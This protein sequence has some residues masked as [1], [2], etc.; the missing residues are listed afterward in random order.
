MYKQTISPSELA[1]L[2]AAYRAFEKL[3]APSGVSP[4]LYLLEPAEKER[5]LRFFTER[6]AQPGEIIVQEDTPGDAIH[7]IS[8]GQTAVI[9]GGFPNPTILGFRGAGEIIGEMA[10]LENSARFASVIALTPLRLLS[11]SSEKFDQ[12]IGENPDISRKIMRVLSS[13][14]RQ[15]GEEK[16]SEQFLSHQVDELREQAV[17]DVLTG[18]FNRR[19]LEETLQREF[20]RARRENLAVSILIMDVDHF[21]HIND[22]YGHQAGDYVLQEFGRLLQ[23]CVRLEDIVC[24]FGGDEFVVVM[25]GASAE[26]A[27]ERGERIRASFDALFLTFEGHAIGATLSMGAATLPAH[28]AGADEV[29]AMADQALYQAKQAG[30]NRVMVAA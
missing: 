15:A 7:L 24:R 26:V 29:L 2:L 30:R 25:P 16:T 4:F 1:M 12:F 9:K 14:L 10:V 11:L 22:T 23:E 8:S 6:V 19:Y 21:K 20:S 18:L 3:P 5:M 17:R 27:R 13:R 28:G